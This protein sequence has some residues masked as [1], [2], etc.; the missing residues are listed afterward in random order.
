M[1]TMKQMRALLVG[2]A[3]AVCGIGLF[4]YEQGGFTSQAAVVTW[5]MPVPYGDKNFHTLN[6]VAFAQ[7]LQKR[8]SGSVT[9]K[10]HPSGS[11]FKHP[12]IK[13]AVRSGQ[14][15]IGEFLLSR[16]SN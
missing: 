5:N 16:L 1:S 13:N 9:I 14:V 10:V 2:C 7:D 6:H 3:V 4:A 12:D 15:P 8:T 11:L